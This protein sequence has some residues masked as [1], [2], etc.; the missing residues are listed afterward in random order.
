[1]ASSDAVTSNDARVPP[2]PTESQMIEALKR[3]LYESE[4]ALRGLRGEVA[5]L[6]ASLTMEKR[7]HQLSTSK[8]SQ[9]LKK[10]V[11]SGSNGDADKELVALKQHVLMQQQ[12]SRLASEREEHLRQQLSSAIKRCAAASA[13]SAGGSC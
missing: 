6:E 1:M 9:L 11:G 4:G 10:R 2:A 7:E 12:Q 8:L 5:S 13:L 3:A